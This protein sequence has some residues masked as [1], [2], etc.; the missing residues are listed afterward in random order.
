MQPS[1]ESSGEQR[2]ASLDGLRGIAITGV[3]LYHAYVH[4]AAVVPWGNAFSGKPWFAYGGLGVQ[5]F[6]M[7]SGFVIA[8]TLRRC[9]SMREFI[10]RR[11]L[12]LFPAMAIVSLLVFCTAW[13][14]P[15]RP[16][17]QPS[18]RDLLPGLLFIE[19]E[20]LEWLPGG[21]KVRLLEGTFWSL[22]VEVKFYLIA[23]ASYFLW[24][25]RGM[26]VALVCLFVTANVSAAVPWLG[27]LSYVCTLASASY[28]GWFASGALFHSHSL[29]GDRRELLAAIF[30]G[31]AAAASQPSRMMYPG[32]F[33]SMVVLVF[34]STMLSAKVRRVVSVRVLLWIGF[35]SY[36][37]YLVHENLVIIGILRLAK[38]APSMPPILLPLLPIA[39]VCA[40]AWLVAAWLEPA[41]RAW[42]RRAT[43]AKA[44]QLVVSNPEGR[45]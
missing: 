28:F 29:S 14:F 22:F 17:G 34:T 35:I 44:P 16:L 33:S 41:M 24:G 13:I 37:L 23:G 2:I 5:L 11:W 45:A 19:A 15:E 8:L 27:G 39:A 18:L 25:R 20:W 32:I 40:L 9:S 6:F 21:Q 10:L 4:W 38:V 3:V 30:V 1:P 42:L 43:R 26:V 36:P 7:I 12:R 31:V